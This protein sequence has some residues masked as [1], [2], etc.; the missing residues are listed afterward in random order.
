MSLRFVA[1]A[2]AFVL[3]VVHGDS[4][5]INTHILDTDSEKYQQA[6][7]VKVKAD[8]EENP[9]LIASCVYN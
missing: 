4:Q 2:S 3:A 7:S 6:L 9:N 8:Q 1:A 5:I